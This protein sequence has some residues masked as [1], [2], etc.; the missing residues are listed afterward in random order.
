[1][2]RS[3]SPISCSSWVAIAD[4]GALVEERVERRD[5]ARRGSRRDRERRAREARGRCPCRRGR[6]ASAGDVRERAAQVGLQHDPDVLVARRAELAVEAQRGVGRRRVLHVDADEVAAR[7]RVRHDRL[8]VLA[9]ELLVE[10]EAEPGELDGDVRVE[11]LL[12]DPLEDTV[13][14][15]PDLGRLRCGEDLLPQDVDRRHLPFGV[16]ALHDAHGVV[17]RGPGDVRRREAPDERARHGGEDPRDRAVE[18]GHDR[19]CS[20]GAV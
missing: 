6:S 13:V 8:E 5:E 4:V 2:R 9:A 19:Q 3:A 16:Q 14:G 7:L 17:E 15:P 18:A 10:L 11:P 20:R 12:L 1:M